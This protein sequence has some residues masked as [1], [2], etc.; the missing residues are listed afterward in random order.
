ALTANQELVKVLQQLAAAKG[1][2]PAQVAL[3]WLLAQRPWIAP[4][5][6]TTKLHRLEE[7]LGASE[8]DLSGEDL[9]AI[10]TALSQVTVEGD[11]Y[12]AHL[13][14]RVGR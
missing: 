5:P 11:R 10:E 8:L 2:T 13:Q 9:D 3:A 14:A 4:I 1:A 7:N 12:P 6:G